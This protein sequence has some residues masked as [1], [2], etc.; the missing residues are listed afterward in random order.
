MNLSRQRTK[1]KIIDSFINQLEHKRYDLIQLKDIIAGANISRST[2]Y[3]HFATKDDLLQEICRDLFYHIFMEESQVNIGIHR[4]LS[5][6]LTHFKDNQ[7]TLYA[8]LSSH[9]PYFIRTFSEHLNVHLEPLLKTTTEHFYSLPADY[10]QQ[11]IIHSFI[12][13]IR[14]WLSNCPDVSEDIII[15][16]YLMIVS[17]YFFET[18]L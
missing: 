1:Q 18:Y 10:L 17:Y 2:F 6:L 16:D 3:T 4:Q 7:K 12:N 11:H 9:E 14:W 15:S 8:L 13:T 5:H